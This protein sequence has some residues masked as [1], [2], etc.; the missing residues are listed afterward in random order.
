MTDQPTDHR[1][2]AKDLDDLIR[3]DFE[4]PLGRC[5][6]AVGHYPGTAH[7][8]GPPT[9][10]PVTDHR[11]EA[12]DWRALAITSVAEGAEG[13]AQAEALIGILSALLAQPPTTKMRIR[14][15]QWETIADYVHTDDN[16]NEAPD[17]D[18][19]G[20]WYGD[21]TWTLWPTSEEA[22]TRCYLGK[23]HAGGHSTG[24]LT[25]TATAENG[26]GT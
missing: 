8:Y 20:W 10:N 22:N 3:C 5:A 24:P 13:F 4:T 17:Q 18:R 23:G 26:D 2:E 16:L 7:Q 25:V 21:D 6:L 19:C 1:A 9:R 15:G 14:D 12:E 11:K